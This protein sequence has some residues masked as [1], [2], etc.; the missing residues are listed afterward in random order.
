MPGPKLVEE[1]HPGVA[2]NRRTKIVERCRRGARPIWT[3][4]SG[5]S[6]RSQHP[7]E[8]RGVQPPLSRVVARDK[9]ARSGVRGPVHKATAAG[10]VIAQVLLERRRIQVLTKKGMKLFLGK[11]PPCTEQY[12]AAVRE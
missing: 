9:N 12:R 11:R 4:S 8:I 1:V 2:A 3:V 6:D 7:E 10:R 5:D